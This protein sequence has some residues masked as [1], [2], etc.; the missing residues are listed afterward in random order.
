MIKDVE[1]WFAGEIKRLVRTDRNWF[2]TKMKHKYIIKQSV[3]M[4]LLYPDLAKVVAGYN[5]LVKKHNVNEEKRAEAAL[6]A[7]DP[8]F[9]PNYE[10]YFGNPMDTSWIETDP[11]VIAA[12]RETLLDAEWLRT[13][14]KKAD[15]NVYNKF[16]KKNPKW[17][18]DLNVYS[19]QVNFEVGEIA[20]KRRTKKGAKYGRV[21][22]FAMILAYWDAFAYIR[23]ELA[24]E[25]GKEFY[26]IGPDG[27][28]KATRMGGEKVI[29]S[30][31]TKQITSG[32][33]KTRKVG[34][35]KGSIK[36]AGLQ[37][38]IARMTLARRSKEIFKKAVPKPTNAPKDWALVTDELKEIV[39]NALEIEYQLK[40]L[41]NV[42]N[43]IFD[44]TQIVN[45]EATDS[46]G[47]K[48]IVDHYDVDGVKAF[49]HKKMKEM[50]PKLAKKYAKT[51]L[52][53]KGSGKTKDVIAAQMNGM[54]ISKLLGLKAFNRPDMR[55]KVNK[56]LLAAA[57][58]SKVKR[59]RKTGTFGS[60]LVASTKVA[61]NAAKVTRGRGQKVKPGGLAARSVNK[62]KTGQSPLAIRNLLNEALPQM[63]ASKMISPALQ[64]RTGRFAN[65]A[66]VEMV[67][68]GPQGGTA[69]DYTYMK[70]PYETFEPGGKQ[71]STQRDPRKVIGQ[72]I[73]EL[74]IGIIGKLPHTIRRT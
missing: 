18:K 11:V 28:D 25:V 42:N 12:L 35:G 24:L 39:Q 38:T 4:R 20:T 8:N 48:G 1:D 16:Q 34:K 44:L 72:S 64:F 36:A 51:A 33:Q 58:K 3:I 32:H 17:I 5:T 57:K 22:N 6:D 13:Y 2:D 61:A 56:K 74:A 46:K 63:V 27:H 21:L 67:H 52:E 43:E 9:E 40:E 29:R 49:I 59:R 50:A 70:S 19:V 54:L 60:G 66:R 15:P 68:Q 69:I 41:R 26:N 7:G 55:L 47:N 30:P 73:R 62:A 71:G 53:M 45:I 14:F 37:D 10:M 31:A 65:S 23:D